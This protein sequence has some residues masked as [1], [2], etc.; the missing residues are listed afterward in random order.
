MVSEEFND[1]VLAKMTDYAYNGEH[2]DSN[3]LL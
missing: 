2:T 3:M 1:K